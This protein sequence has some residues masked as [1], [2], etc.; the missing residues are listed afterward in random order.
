M[1]GAVGAAVDCS[2]ANAVKAS[3]AGGAWF[4]RT[5]AVEGS[6]D[7]HDKRTPDERAEIFQSDL[8]S[9]DY[10]WC[11]SYGRLHGGS[12]LAGRVKRLCRRAG[13]VYG[14]YLNQQNHRHQ[15][16]DGQMGIPNA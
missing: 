5:D 8:H 2:R 14:V 10:E 3:P 7:G 13:R 4:N 9:I 15:F 16:F 11:D 1:I 6:G 12:W